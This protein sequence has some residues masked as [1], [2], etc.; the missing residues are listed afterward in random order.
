MIVITPEP[1]GDWRSKRITF[2]AKRNSIL[3]PRPCLVHS[4]SYYLWTHRF[5]KWFDNGDDKGAGTFW[6]NSRLCFWRAMVHVAQTTGICSRHNQYLWRCMPVWFAR[7]QSHH[8]SKN[9]KAVFLNE[10]WC[11]P[12]DKV[13]AFVAVRARAA[14]EVSLPS[15][16]Q[17][18]PWKAWRT[19]VDVIRM[20][21]PPV[22]KNSARNWGKGQLAATGKRKRWHW[23]EAIEMKDGLQVH[24]SPLSRNGGDRVQMHHCNNHDIPGFV[25]KWGIPR[26]HG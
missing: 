4:H 13:G 23:Q 21:I 17:T 6:W 14:I 12:G 15:I 5:R 26:N 11:N 7:R 10:A 8:I 9:K 3:Q 19:C 18:P 20:R 16:M 22:W 1:C 2:T 24:H 25:C